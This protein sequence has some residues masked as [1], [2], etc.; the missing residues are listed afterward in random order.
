MFLFEIDKEDTLFEKNYNASIFYILEFP[1]SEDDCEV[2]DSD[3]Y[4][5][6]QG[7]R[8]A[9]LISATTAGFKISHPDIEDENHH[10][11]HH[12][13]HHQLPGLAEFL[14]DHQVHDEDSEEEEDESQEVPQALG[15]FEAALQAFIVALENDPGAPHIEAQLAI[16]H[17]Q[18]AQQNH[19][20]IG[21]NNAPLNN[22]PVINHLLM[23][24]EFAINVGGEC[25]G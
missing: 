19:I 13:N 24:G 2:G 20:N 11:N 23:D 7:K 3:D 21:N 5:D 9:I 4:D 1:K 18:L 15:N 22:V 12:L 17:A 10:F 14:Q 8:E 6:G 25:A 16:A